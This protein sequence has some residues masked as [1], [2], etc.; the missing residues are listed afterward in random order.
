MLQASPI[1]SRARTE[2]R[3]L[4]QMQ[5]SGGAMSACQIA[6]ELDLNLKSVRTILRDLVSAEVIASVGRDSD[7]PIFQINA[8]AITPAGD[9]QRMRQYA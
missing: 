6:D 2:C 5:L 7:G 3:I 1:H 4:E 8:V 9:S